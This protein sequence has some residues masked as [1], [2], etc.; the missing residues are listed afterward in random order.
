M[1]VSQANP[2]TPY[3]QENTSRE[4]RQDG[5]GA[6]LPARLPRSPHAHPDTH[7][8]PLGRDSDGDV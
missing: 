3:V 2:S 7:R 1:C 6:L 8:H 4:R 5:S